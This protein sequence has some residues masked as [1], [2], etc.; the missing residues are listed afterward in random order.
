MLESAVSD[1]AEPVSALI[2]MAEAAVVA[3]DQS[4][5]AISA[6]VDAVEAD[7]SDT[8]LISSL[9]SSYS[10]AS[11]EA[12]LDDADIG[13]VTGSLVNDPPFAEDDAVITAEDTAITISPNALLLND[14]DI[15]GDTI[16]IESVGNPTHGTVNIVDG[17]VVFTPEADFFGVATFEYTVVDQQG[18]Q[19]TDTASVTVNVTPVADDSVY[20]NDDNPDMQAEPG[21][22]KVIDPA[23]LLANDLDP[24]TQDNVG[25]TVTAVSNPV[26]GTVAL[27]D[28][29]IN[30]TPLD[31]YLGNASFDYEIENADGHSDV[32]T[33]H[34]KVV[35]PPVVS[36]EQI[37]LV[38]IESNG[39]LRVTQEELLANDYEF[40][41]G[42]NASLSIF[43][44]QNP[45]GGSVTIDDNGDIIFT[46]TLVIRGS[47]PLNTPSL[48][49]MA[50]RHQALLP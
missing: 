5:D 50:G 14:V 12:A 22:Q 27:V 3:Q 28:G 17:N 42:T 10:G 21:V 39:D 49:G 29:Q 46:P 44:V 7:A 15:D 8:S 48:M 35:R 4:A 18:S 40:G 16:T 38:Q 43:S 2:K 24:D 1:S 31:D 33:V 41:V 19:L 36:P 45:I 47:R 34:V 25:L 9:V 20:A 26:G 13:D 23:I 30:F 37:T 6:A 32:A 11:L